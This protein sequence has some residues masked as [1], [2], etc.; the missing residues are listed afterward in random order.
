MNGIV[1]V[2]KP[3][4][5]SS[6]DVVDFVRRAFDIKKAG[7]TGTLDPAAAGVLV[8]CLGTAT[9]LAR[10]LLLEDKEYR[11]E[12]TFGLSTSS[13]DAFG[14][15][16]GEGDASKIV[17]EKVRSVLPCFTGEILQ[18]PPMESALKY[19]GQKLYQLARKGIVVERQTRTA[20]IK[21]LEF[22]W[23][24]G[25]GSRHPRALLHL[26]C[27]KGT[28]VRSL[29]D[30]IGERLG[31]GAYMSFLVRTKVGSFDISDSVTLEEIRSAAGSGRLAE[32]VVKM[33][34]A[35]PEFPAVRIKAGAVASAVSGAKIYPPG[36]ESLN[37]N[38]HSGDIVRLIGPEGLLALARAEVDEEKKGGM[39]FKPVCVLAQ[40]GGQR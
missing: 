19:R 23:G 13:G 38:I 26:S 27:S 18:V 24:T 7:H 14:E 29:C 25:W 28:Y 2:L 15:I 32:K 9:R 5:M 10:F 17:E 6:H 30:D 4:G 37:G 21:S 34:D 16:V 22:V 12:I 40:Q 11:F 35:L 8:V 33:E 36:V 31:C 20:H 39:A 3:P 1:N